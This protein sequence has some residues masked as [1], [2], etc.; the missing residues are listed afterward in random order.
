[1]STFRVAGVLSLDG[2]RFTAG[3][4]RA[5]T[6]ASRFASGVSR[7][8]GGKLAGLFAVGALTAFAKKTVEVADGLVVAAKRMGTTVEQVQV[9]QKAAHDSGTEIGKLEVAFERLNV[10]RGKALGG[11]K[12]SMAAFSALGITESDLR[13]KSAASLFTGPMASYAKG[14]SVESVGP[15]LRDIFGR[16]FGEALAVLNQ[17]LAETEA[18]LKKFGGLMSGET[19]YG[20]K[21]L[22]DNAELVSSILTAQFGPA[23]LKLAVECYKWALQF[24]GGIAGVSASAG[25]GTAKMSAGQAAVAYGKASAIGMAGLAKRAAGQDE[26]EVTAWVKSKMAEAGFDVKA[27]ED[28]MSTAVN[29]F[30]SNLDQIEHLLSKLSE[31]SKRPPPVPVFD[32]TL[33][34][35]KSSVPKRATSFGKIDSDSLVAVGNFL[36]AG[37]GASMQ[38]IAVQQLDVQR[39]M[40]SKLTEIA[41]ED[42]IDEGFGGN[43]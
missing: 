17:D 4:S 33:A 43:D 40:L 30:Q 28:A 8:I 26:A 34:A 1:M 9:L 22:K 11:D 19:A 2:S 29:P 41:D 16:G 14:R 10:A 20:L 36:G 32:A 3:L 23:L 27:M 24:A 38:R 39:Q 6:A 13:T 21:M 18:Q 5:E 35:G 37:T 42:S 25:A 15:I 31:D 7:S 12:K